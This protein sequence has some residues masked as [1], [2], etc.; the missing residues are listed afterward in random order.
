MK[1]QVRVLLWGLFSWSASDTAQ[2]YQESN[3]CGRR[4][5]QFLFLFS[6]CM[7]P[8]TF[9]LLSWWWQSGYEKFSHDGPH[10]LVLAFIGVYSYAISSLVLFIL[11]GV[12]PQPLDLRNLHPSLIEVSSPSSST[13]LKSRADIPGKI[14]QPTAPNL[15][16][17][18]CTASI[19]SWSMFNWITPL[20]MTGYR[21]LLTK[22]DLYDL[23]YQHRAASAHNDYRAHN[24]SG[25][26]LSWRRTLRS[27]YYANRRT[28]WIQFTLS[29]FTVLLSYLR[30]YLQERLLRYIETYH[31]HGPT[32]DISVAYMVAF[33]LFAAALVTQLLNNIGNWAGR[34]WSI[35]T[36]SML[37]SELFA[38]TL[39]RKAS[40]SQGEEDED[41]RA[42]KIVNLMSVDTNCIAEFPVCVSMLYTGPLE[43][44]IALVYL[45]KLLGVAA[46][47]GLAVLIISMPATWLFA[48]AIRSTYDN[49][50]TTRDKRGR[51]VYELF[52]GIH[53]IK[54]AAW[55]H[56]WKSKILAARKTELR[57]LAKSF[58]L[59]I[60]MSI[61][62]YTL[63]ILI[64]ACSFVWYVKVEGHTLSPS[65][66]FVSITLFDML[67][68]PVLFIP[69]TISI[70]TRTGVSLKRISD[71]LG[72]PEKENNEPVST[73]HDYGAVKNPVE[74]IKS[75]FVGF[76]AGSSF[77]WP[78]SPKQAH[79]FKLT[80]PHPIVFPAHQ[81]SLVYGPTGSGKTALLH[82][83]LGE[84]ETVSGKARLSTSAITNHVVGYVAQQSFIL[85][86]TIR[87]NILFGH[88]YDTERY[89]KVIEQCALQHDFAL[90]PH[91][92]QTEVG[93]KGIS[94]SGGQKQRISLARAVY[95]AAD[96]LLLDDCLSAVD[97]HT[98]RHIVDYCL[99]GDLVRNRRTVILVTHQVQLCL[100]LSSY[101]V[102]IDSGGTVSRNGKTSLCDSQAWVSPLQHGSYEQL[103]QSEQES[104]TTMLSD[105]ATYDQTLIK[106]EESETGNVKL[107]IYSIYFQAWGGW[108]F[109]AV[110]VLVFI[111]SR[112]VLFAERW[113]LRKWAM[114][115]S[116]KTHGH[117]TNHYIMVYVFLCALL[118]L[119]DTLRNG[120]MI[121]GSLRSASIFFRRLLDRLVNA[122]LR[123][124]D[125]TPIGRIVNR[126]DA[127]MTVIDQHMAQTSGLLFDCLAGVIASTLIISFMIPLFVCAAALTIAIYLYIG[128]YYLRTSRELK[129][130]SSTSRS[131]LYSHFSEV[132]TGL[133]TIRAYNECQ[134]FLQQ[135]YEKVDESNVPCY[136]LWM[137]NG[138]LLTRIQVAGASLTLCA[139]I[140]IIQHLD[141]VDAG[142]AGII[143][144]YASNFLSRVYWVIRQYTQVEMNLNA[145]ERIQTY[146]E[147]DQE[148]DT[149]R[150]ITKLAWS[151]PATGAIRVCNLVARYD[152]HLPPVL[153]NISFEIYDK[154]K[155]GV[156]GR[157]GAGKSSLALCF[158]RFLKIS[159]A[160]Y[161]DGV[162]I[163]Q[164]NLHTLR[165]S[166]TMIPQNATL[167][168]GTLRTNLDPFQEYTDAAML[169]VLHRVQLTNFDLD[170]GISD[171]GKN[172]SQGQ[173]QLVCMARAL[174]RRSRVV[175]MD[176]ATA[177]IDLETDAIIQRSQR[178]IFK[179]STVICI[180]HRIQTIL[181]YDRI[182][183]LDDGKLVEFDTPKRLLERTS[184][185]FRSMYEQQ[186][187]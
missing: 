80:V 67:R 102:L 159:G 62:F 183:V 89:A 179:D 32:A 58:I 130:F 187:W 178:H 78:S 139:T 173:R 57:Y 129:R 94:L 15:T 26:E 44:T 96:V 85:Q 127:D 92:D 17:P 113:W 149:N 114:E 90:L 16:S 60:I 126:F 100:P 131:P 7:L 99:G 45:S 132:L 108:L 70:M 82:A 49:L 50:S 141:T 29:N 33:G 137:T 68:S 174:L 55:E 152:S 182:M 104:V 73:P 103:A 115:Y 52:Q 140:L 1:T 177:S 63:P 118:V 54:Y 157:T 111:V 51:L 180:A 75:S 46:F 146:I 39:R 186:P 47:V 18:E 4:P 22:D 79:T 105:A 31:A 166:L 86:T 123:F 135:M 23:T 65:I 12:S 116:A 110:L 77:H 19:L 30:P 161:L 83:L 91:G 2:N 69:D 101:F 10:L 119:F 138:W 72:S 162:P 136:L 167:F 56:G 158:F 25:S 84:M 164:I 112:A 169:D 148:D 20:L 13:P 21:R 8:D 24:T 154:E 160:I 134:R 147:C 6:S 122:P 3:T 87:S 144:I 37:D 142:M 163:H 176:E 95:S 165:S 168:A 66:V 143:L 133:T 98:A 107:K 28:I 71:F 59:D 36:R 81:L 128:R 11:C 109:S 97:P 125:T 48:Q 106:D 74:D 5:G 76:D 181:D 9:C 185:V 153:Q 150:E 27:I 88:P 145:V 35:R 156:V 151:W 124:F 184:S 41:G 40:A 14:Y 121:Y 120:I 38:K 53:M 61:G 93:E 42:G 34:H 117:N 43:I 171:E 172:L 175:I 155:I 170:A 64:S